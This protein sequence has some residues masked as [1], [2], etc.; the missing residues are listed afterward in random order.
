MKYNQAYHFD[1]EVELNR[2]EE[3]LGQ[4]LGKK[5]TSLILWQ[6]FL[7]LSCLGGMLPQVIT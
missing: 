3:E 4:K 7:V 5:A 1:Q 2:S 6:V